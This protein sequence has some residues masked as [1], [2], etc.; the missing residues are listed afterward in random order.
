LAEQIKKTKSQKAQLKLVASSVGDFI[1]YWGFRRIHGQ[2][3]TQ[4]YL[5]QYELSGADLAKALGVSKALVSPALS[6]L[7]AYQL[8]EAIDADGRTKKYSANPKVFEVIQ[9]ILKKRERQ[10]IAKAKENFDLLKALKP[11]NNNIVNQERLDSLGAMISAGSLAIDVV[12]SSVDQG[13]GSDWFLSY[14]EKVK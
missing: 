8:I 11:E 6:E 2:L 3:W 13:Q 7:I 14:D 9:K 4:I 10:L 12:I 1:R 5:S